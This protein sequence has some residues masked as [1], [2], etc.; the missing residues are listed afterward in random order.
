MRQET[1]STR[2]R[3]ADPHHLALVIEGGG[4]RGVVSGGMV[5]ALEARGLLDCFDSIHGSSAGACAGAYFLAGQARLG[6]RIY[7]EDIN[8]K[9][10]IDRWR[11]WIGRP[12]YE[13]AFLDRRCYAG[14][15]AASC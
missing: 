11:P 4:M 2:S 8:N 13:R 5:T 12:N 9:R 3:R 6:T 10:F 1:H 15:Q 14:E 7:Y